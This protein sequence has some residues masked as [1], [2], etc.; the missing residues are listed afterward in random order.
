MI[1][2]VKRVVRACR[3]E[4]ENIKDNPPFMDNLLQSTDSEDKVSQQH[5][6]ERHQSS[7]FGKKHPNSHS[8]LAGCFFSI[9]INIISY[10]SLLN[11]F[12]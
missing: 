12:P 2:I 6:E 5:V 11:I 1:D 9:L 4:G 8:C 7:D 3:E 10:F